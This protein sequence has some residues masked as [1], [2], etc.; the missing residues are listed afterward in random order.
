MALS[1]PRPIHHD[2]PAIQWTG[3][4]RKVKVIESFMFFMGP[5]L[6]ARTRESFIVPVVP[7]IRHLPRRALWHCVGWLLDGHCFSNLLPFFQMC[8]SHPWQVFSSIFPDVRAGP[9][10]V[11][12]SQHVN[13]HAVALRVK[14]LN[15]ALCETHCQNSKYRTFPGGICKRTFP[16]KGWWGWES[17]CWLVIGITFL[18]NRML[19]V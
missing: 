16:S 4:W 2:G 19:I 18:E 1:A 8:G 11:P 6:F 5:W 17:V 13:S 7:L 9:R 12:S 15:F 14:M 10:M 3:T